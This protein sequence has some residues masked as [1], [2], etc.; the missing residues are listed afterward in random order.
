MDMH[1]SSGWQTGVREGCCFAVVGDGEVAVSK[2]G[3][4]RM[5]SGGL[6]VL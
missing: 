6:V 5:M 4:K 1:E 2:D 3:L